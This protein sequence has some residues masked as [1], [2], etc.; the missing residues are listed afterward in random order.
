MHDLSDLRT[1]PS[2]GRTYHLLYLVYAGSKKQSSRHDV[3]VVVPVSRKFRFFVRQWHTGFMSNCSD[4][5]AAI[6]ARCAKLGLSR[7]QAQALADAGPFPSTVEQV[8]GF[9]NKPGKRWLWMAAQTSSV[10]YEDTLTPE[11]LLGVLVIGVVPVEFGAHILHFV[12]EAPIP[13]VVQAVEEA[14]Q[15][16]GMPIS[17]IWANMRRLGGQRLLQ[18]LSVSIDLERPHLTHDRQAAGDSGRISQIE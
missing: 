18:A 10:S 14:S 1:Y 3:G 8:L 7:P 2:R 12:E 5:D 13:M 11:A 4:Q 15:Q 6:A 16:S 9:D 17:E